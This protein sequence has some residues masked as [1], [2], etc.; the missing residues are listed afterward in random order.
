MPTD[1]NTYKGIA[2]PAGADGK[3]EIK[4]LAE[5]PVWEDEIYEIQAG[6]LL[7]GGERGL[8]NLQAQQLANRT[9]W[10]KK[11]AGN[12]KRIKNLENMMMELYA[13]RETESKT[14]DGY[15]GIMVETFADGA[16][17]IDKAEAEV[18]SVASDRSYAY[19]PSGS[20]IVARS[21]YQY[22]DRDHVE[23]VQV[24]EVNDNN[25]KKQV[26]FEQPLASS[27]NTGS[28]KLR[29]TTAAVADGRSYGGKGSVENNSVEDDNPAFA[30]VDSGQD[31]SVSLDFKDASA[32]NVTGSAYVRNGKLAAKMPIAYGIALATAGG[33]AG[34]WQ[35]I[36][37][38]GNNLTNAD[39]DAMKG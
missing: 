22:V 3:R 14:P 24:K 16:D 37:V 35:R 33:G 10:L 2:S 15:S 17:E 29:R 1:P 6:D 25:D 26:V 31:L 4:N 19:V 23:E 20:W 12:N 32:F 38:D 8:A 13:A 34:V 18:L 7:A 21:S 28:A 36:N 11:N 9:A 30:G 5:E 27:S 39:V